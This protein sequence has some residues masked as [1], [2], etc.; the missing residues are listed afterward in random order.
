MSKIIF[1]TRLNV[2]LLVTRFNAVQRNKRKRTNKRFQRSF[3]PLNLAG[4]F[5]QTSDFVQLDFG[6]DLPIR[7]SETKI[8]G[9]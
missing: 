7:E 3:E 5:T 2:T 6:F 1:Q 8:T 9:V 4:S